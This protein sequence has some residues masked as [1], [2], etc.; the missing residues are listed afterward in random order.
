MVASG[1]DLVARNIFQTKFTS[2]LDLWPMWPKTKG[3]F[4]G[5]WAEF[6]TP[7]ANKTSVSFYSLSISPLSQVRKQEVDDGRPE[8]CKWRVGPLHEIPYP[9]ASGYELWL[10]R[11]MWQ[12]ILCK[13]GWTESWTEREV[14]Q[15]IYPT[16]LLIGRGGGVYDN[17]YVK[18]QKCFLNKV[19]LWPWPLNL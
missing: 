18:A 9:V 16:L 5:P 12:K 2:D 13:D 4:L 14:N 15:Y 3:H 6:L 8:F 1:R 19:H 10:P 17:F 11:K 7:Q